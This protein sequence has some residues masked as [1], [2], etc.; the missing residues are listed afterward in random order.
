M[1]DT[2]IKKGDE[3]MS[4]DGVRYSVVSAGQRIVSVRRFVE[5]GAPRA[6]TEFYRSH[7]S[8]YFRPYNEE[9]S[10]QLLKLSMQKKQIHEAHRIAAENECVELG[11]KQNALFFN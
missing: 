2:N 7:F 9:V 1:W 10:R 5:T 4:S 6:A 8:E 11:Q 3:V